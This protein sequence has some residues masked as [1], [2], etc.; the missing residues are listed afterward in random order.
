MT[1]SDLQTRSRTLLNEP[2]A[3]FYTDANLTN[4][5]NDGLN[6]ITAETNSI[7]ALKTDSTVAYQQEYTL[8]TDCIRPKTVY[9]EDDRLRPMDWDEYLSKYARSDLFTRSD[10]KRFMFWNNKLFLYP[11]PDASATSATLSVSC[12]SAST[13]VRVGSTSDYPTNG[14]VKIESELISYTNTTATKFTGC[15][16]GLENSTAVSHAAAT[17]VTE[18]DISYVYYGQQVTALSAS[19][20]TPSIPARFHILLVYYMVWMGYLSSKELKEAMAYKELFERGLA[21]MKRKMVMDR[22][23]MYYRT[24]KDYSD[25]E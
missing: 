1:L 15:S 6:I 9:W 16:R 20:D 3:G 18:R 7:E 17:T 2:T 11:V 8:A 24:I 19:G 10:P 12:G 25:Y 22:G 14:R 21:D 13:T 5:A 23:A 4:W